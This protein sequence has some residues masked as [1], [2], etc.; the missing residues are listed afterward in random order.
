MI[1]G[2]LFSR[3]PRQ[4]REE[5]VRMLADALNALDYER[6][7]YLLAD[8]IVVFNSRRGTINGRANFIEDDRSFRTSVSGLRIEIADLIHHDHEVLVR[9]E[10]KSDRPDI[11][12]PTLWRLEFDGPLISRIEITRRDPVRS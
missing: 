10:L 4:Q 7:G 2:T 9:G 6:A 8:D 11:G 5:S 3:R 1:W 12:G